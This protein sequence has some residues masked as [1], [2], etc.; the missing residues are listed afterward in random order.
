MSLFIGK[1]Y[2]L[3]QNFVIDHKGNTLIEFKM[4]LGKITEFLTTKYY[5]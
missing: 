1:I 3:N 4:Y 5:F 2:A